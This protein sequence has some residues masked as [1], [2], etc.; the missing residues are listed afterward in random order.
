MSLVHAVVSQPRRRVG[1]PASTKTVF[2]LQ[3][4]RLRQ[5]YSPP[6]YRPLRVQKLVVDTDSQVPAW[7]DALGSQDGYDEYSQLTNYGYS[8]LTH[9]EYSQLIDDDFCQRGVDDFCQILPEY[10]DQIAPDDYCQLVA[11]QEDFGLYVI[12]DRY[13]GSYLHLTDPTEGWGDAWF[14]DGEEE[15]LFDDDRPSWLELTSEVARRVDESRRRRV[16]SRR[17]EKRS[18][19]P[20]EIWEPRQRGRALGWFDPCA[21]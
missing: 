18:R 1:Q 5:E 16:T 13:G 19:A 17:I 12:D 2:T 8:P 11:Y 4:V 10:L 7:W 14:F 9:Y 21:A 15:F 6:Q 3:D 20:K